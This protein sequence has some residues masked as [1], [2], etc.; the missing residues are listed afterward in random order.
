MGSFDSY[1][2]PGYGSWAGAPWPVVPADYTYGT[3]AT[4]YYDPGLTLSI[5]NPPKEEVKVKTKKYTVNL[6]QADIDGGCQSHASNCPGALA[7]NRAVAPLGLYSHVCF[8]RVSFTLEPSDVAEEVHSIETPSMLGMFVSAFDTG[9]TVGPFSFEIELPEDMRFH[10]VTLTGKEA[11]TLRAI[12][13]SVGGNPTKSPRGHASTLTAKLDKAGVRPFGKIPE[14]D[15]KSGDLM[16]RD[17]PDK[18]DY[19]GQ[20]W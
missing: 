15:F 5:P 4:Y 9:N 3:Y 8:S 19:P 13:A 16:F 7:I 18:A 20:R 14:N 17:Y 10:K 2:A 12:L 1:T 11:D 6:T